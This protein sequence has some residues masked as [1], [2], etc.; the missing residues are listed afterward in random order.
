MNVADM[1]TYRRAH[2]SAGELEFIARYIAPVAAPVAAPDGT[3]HAYTATVGDAP[4]VAF[5]AHTDSVHNR[6]NPA[7]RQPVAYD[8]ARGEYFVKD[9]KQRDCLGADNAAGCYV[10]LRMLAARVPGRYFFFRGEERGG[11]GSGWIADNRADL[12]A[13]IN[14]AIQF[15][16]R[17]THSVITN[18]ACGRTC[19]DEFADSLA[20]ILNMGHERDPTGSF[21]DT[22]NLAAIVAECTNVSVGY[23]REH[24]QHEILDARYL[25]RLTRACI[26]AFKRGD[27]PLV[28]VRAPG[29][30]E[31]AT[32][33]DS[34]MDL[35]D[36]EIYQLAQDC[37]RD[38]L[39]RMLIS[40]RTE[41][42]DATYWSR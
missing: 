29:D 23:D 37:D 24:S 17:A 35:T 39:A 25:E 36:E 21:T 40:A 31:D 32:R 33:G 16:R 9:E 11:I 14:A 26:H 18:M 4:T 41:L 27:A 15:D 3:I 2:D 12:F 19:S 34:L 6:Q 13:G 42:E 20:D 8:T 22:A 7:T 1:L 38:T 28:I 5:C 10:L 30:F